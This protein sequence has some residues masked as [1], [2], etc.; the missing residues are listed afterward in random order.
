[1]LPQT[2][3]FETISGIFNSDSVAFSYLIFEAGLEIII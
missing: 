3:S 1:M 2:V